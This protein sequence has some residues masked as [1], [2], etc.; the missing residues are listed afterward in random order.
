MGLAFVLTA[1]VLGVVLSYALRP[2]WLSR[3][4]AFVSYVE[5]RFVERV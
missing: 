5:A 1:L 3:T 2:L 4:F